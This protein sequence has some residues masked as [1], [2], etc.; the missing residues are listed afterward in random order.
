MFLYISFFITTNLRDRGIIAVLHG[1][2]INKETVD[3][4]DN[5]RNRNLCSQRNA[6][7]ICVVMQEPVTFYN[8]IKRKIKLPCI[9]SQIGNAEMNYKVIKKNGQ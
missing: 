9:C 8:Q 1:S 6:D 4:K 5:L 2:V 3:S 7:Y